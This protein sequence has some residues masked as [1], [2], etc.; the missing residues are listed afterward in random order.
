MAVKCF[1]CGIAERKAEGKLW[2]H[3][4][5]IE[6]TDVT[7]KEKSDC[8]YY[9]EPQYEDG[10]PLTAMQTLM[11]KECEVASRRMRGPV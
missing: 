1:S 4:Y 7:A 2:C 3:K 6:I 10:E 5:K 8:Y 11:I 9:I